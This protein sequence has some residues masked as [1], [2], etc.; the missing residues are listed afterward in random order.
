MTT[1]NRFEQMKKVDM[2]SNVNPLVYEFVEFFKK[3]EKDTQFDVKEL[4]FILP[5]LRG[6]A[7]N[8][9][10]EL[11]MVECLDLCY[12]NIKSMWFVENFERFLMLKDGW[13]DRYQYALEELKK[14]SA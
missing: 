8:N 9:P 10:D 12:V 14:V 11:S 4:Y 2:G 6:Y 7:I 3:A 1:L 13:L 5:T